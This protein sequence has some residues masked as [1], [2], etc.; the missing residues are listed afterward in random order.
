MC[1]F[2]LSRRHLLCRLLSLFLSLSLSFSPSLSLSRSR[3][4]FLSL[5]FKS[6]PINE[7][8]HLRCRRV[9][10]KSNRYL[11]FHAC[12]ALP[13]PSC[14]WRVV[15]NC[16]LNTRTVC[17]SL[18]LSLVKDQIPDEFKCPITRYDAH[19]LSNDAIFATATLCIDTLRKK[20]CETA[21][22]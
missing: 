6:T 2:Y 22:A 11:Y 16:R 1:F 9:L 21:R 19:L 3:S 20:R 13:H 7:L 8:G 12:S 17:G 4:R 5:S 18:S 15:L 10:R 14:L